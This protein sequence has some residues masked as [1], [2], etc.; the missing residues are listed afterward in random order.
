MLDPER[1]RLGT[2]VK[3]LVCEKGHILAVKE[4]TKDVLVKHG[5]G[6]WTLHRKR[7]CGNCGGVLTY[8][9]LENYTQVQE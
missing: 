7:Y 2:V 8:P 9:L 4:S 5:C 6:G 3:L 1:I